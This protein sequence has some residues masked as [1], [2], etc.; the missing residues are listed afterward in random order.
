MADVN[1][2]IQISLDTSQAQAQLRQL[3]SQISSFN[4][5]FTAI[6]SQGAQQAQAMNRALMDGVNATKMFNARIIPVTSTVERFSNSLEKGKLS[7]GEYSRYATSQLPGMRKVFSQEFQMME[8]VATER[9][10]KMQA[11][12]VALGKSA[13]GAQEAMSITPTTLSRG[14]GT[15]MAV[16]VQR[17]QMFNKLIDDG[18]TKLLNW[19]KNTQWAG[20]QLMVGFTLPLAAL[21]TVAAQT[22]MELDKASVSF[23]RVYGDLSTTT[24][25]MEKNK[26]ALMDL[27][28]EY[29][30]Y[31]TSVADTVNLGARVAATGLEGNDMLA[32]TEQ[33]LRFATLGQM[34]YNTALDATISLQSAFKIESQDLAGTIDFLNAVENQTVLTIQ[35]IAA[36]IPRVAPVIKGLGG[37]VKDLAV[38]LTAMREGGVSAEQGSNALKSGLASLIN[39]TARATES[40]SKLGINMDAIINQNKGDLLGTVKAFGEALSVVGE[41]EQ[42]QALEQ[43]FGKFQYARMGALFENIA[44]SSSQATRAMDIM[45]MSMEELASLS[46]K[47]L[48]K[49]EEST[50]VK[51]EKAL[52]NLRLAIAPLGEAFL[53]GIMPIMEFLSNL[54]NAFNN[55]PD[56]IKNAMAVIVG[57]VGGLGPVF[58]MTLGLI[59]NGFANL[60]KGVQVLRK[61]LA[62]IR[63][64]A[65]N[66][67]VLSNAEIEA[68]GATE[69]LDGSVQGLTGSLLI[70][71]R[72]VAALNREYERYAAVAGL[73]GAAARTRG[74][75]GGPPPVKM[76]KGGVVPGTGSGDKIPALLEPGESVVTKKASQR[77]G[78]VIAAMNAGTL[79]GY[80]DGVVRVGSPEFFS[81][82]GMSEK[83][84]Q[85][86]SVQNFSTR[87]LQQA[88][89]VTADE[90]SN[91]A[92]RFQELGNSAKSLKTA[93]I[94]VVGKERTPSMRA[95]NR[96]SGGGGTR[97][98]RQSETFSQ[99][100]M[101]SNEEAFIRERL[102]DSVREEMFKIDASH[103]EKEV[104]DGIKQWRPENL[105][106]DFAGVNQTL[107]NR[108]KSYNAAIEK[109]TISV[110]QTASMMR[111]QTPDLLESLS[112]EE[113]EFEL[114]RLRQGFHPVTQ[115][116]TRVATSF[117]ELDAALSRAALGV[118]DRTAIGTVAA[119][120]RNAEFLA[121][122]GQYR[123]G[124][125]REEFFGEGGRS[126]TR[127]QEL[128]QRGTRDAEA[129][130]RGADAVLGPDD[131]PYLLTTPL[132]NSPHP[133][134][135]PDGRQDAQAYIT[136]Q[137][138]ELGRL[139]QAGGMSAKENY[140][141]SQ[142]EA[143]GVAYRESQMASIGMTSTQITRQER[144]LLETKIRS[145]QIKLKEAQRA[146]F[147]A[148]ES[149]RIANQ[150]N[151]VS[152]AENVSRMAAL[153]SRAAGATSSVMGRSGMIGMALGMGSMVPMMQ[154]NMGLGMGMMGAG[155]GLEMLGQAQKARA[156]SGAAGG[157]GTMA[158]LL[159][160]LGML[161]PPI[162]AAT[163]AV[164][165]LAIGAK[166]YRE[167]QDE[168]ARAA[169]EFGSNVGLAANS[170]NIMAKI[171]NTLTPAQRRA[172][173]NVGMTE[174]EQEMAGQFAS[175]FDSE[176]GSK[177]V[178]DLENATSAER[179]QKLSDYLRSAIAAGIMDEQVAVAFAKNMAVQLGDAVLGIQLQR[180]IAGQGTG[181]AAL[182]S[183][184]QERRSATA[185]LGAYEDLEG[186]GYVSGE[187]AGVIVGSALQNIQ[188]FANVIALAEEEY[189]SGTLSYADYND[190]VIQARAEMNTYTK[191]LL[192]TASKTSDVG[193]TMQA[194]NQELLAMGMTEEQMSS[195]ADAAAQDTSF[196]ER[197]FEGYDGA[198]RQR[199]DRQREVAGAAAFA[200]GMSPEN[201]NTALDFLA[202]NPESVANEI[203][204]SLMD[205]GQESQA[206]AGAIA[207]QTAAAGNVAGIG[208]EDQ[209]LYVKVL[210]EF[211][212]T[213]GTV[214]DFS[215]FLETIPEEKRVEIL[216]EF[217][218]LTPE[219]K[220]ALMKD[221]ASLRDVVGP[222]MAADIATSEGFKQGDSQQIIGNLDRLSKVFGGDQEKIQRYVELFLEESP[223]GF[224]GMLPEV[225]NDLELLNQIP[226]DIRS[227][228]GIDLENP[229]D[230][231]K[232][233]PLA[234]GIIRLVPA[235]EALPD[236]QKEVATNLMLKSNGEV[237]DP[238][239]FAKDVASYQKALDKLSS[240]K[241]EVRKEAAIDLITTITGPNGETV[242]AEDAPN[243]L[244]TALD[245]TG[246]TEGEFLQLP[247]DQIS[248]ILSLAIEAQGL[249]ESATT[250]QAMGDAAM[251]LQ[252]SSSAARY[253]AAAAAA[254]T[255]AGKAKES[256]KNQAAAGIVTGGN[257]LP[258]SGGGGGG[259]DK[260]DPFKDMKK[261]ILDQIQSYADM[262]ETMKTLFG[263]KMN[264]FDLVNK[265]KGIDDKIRQLNL[266]PALAEQISSMD[267][268]DAKKVLNR[269][270]KG[271]KLNKQGQMVNRAALAGSV[272]Q[273]TSDAATQVADSQAQM[274]ALASLKTRGAASAEAISSIAGD[275]AAAKEYLALIKEADK[276]QKALADAGGR[277]GKKLRTAYNEAKG[278]V[279]EYIDKIVE[280][281]RKAA[282]VDAVVSMEAD[283][284]TNKAA[285]QALN[286]LSQLS[287]VN[288]DVQDWAEQN[289][290]QF[291]N[292]IA[293][294]DGNIKKAIAAIQQNLASIEALKSP[295][296]IMMEELDSAYQE[297]QD[298]NEDAK[299]QFELLFVAIEQ[300]YEGLIDASK[301]RVEGLQDAIKIVQTEIDSLQRL[302]DVD[303]R[304]IRALERQKELMSRQVEAIE[305]Q[306]E[307]DQRRADALNRQAEM[308]NRQIEILDRA[309]ELD[310]R[311]IDALGRQI[312]MMTRQQD[313][314]NDQIA[315]QE[316]LNE[317]DQRQID[318]ITRSDELRQRQAEALNRELELMSRRE[319]EIRT[320]YDERIKQLDEVEQVQERI[321][322][323]SKSQLDLAKALASGDI[324]SAAAAAQQMRENQ[325]LSAR[326]DVRTAM[327]Q[328]MEGQVGALR[329]SGGLTREQAEGQVTGIQ[330]QSYQAQ[331]AIR[332]IQDQI[333][334]RTQELIPL[335]DQLYL[336]DQNI[337]TVN[338]EIQVIQ[339][340]VY[341]REL[342][343]I[344][345]LEQ[346]R[347][348]GI[349]VRD[350]ED[351]IYNRNLETLPI[352]DAIYNKDLEIR[353]VQD[354]IFNRETEIMNIQVAR[355]QP[356]QD[357]LNKE[358]D[359]LTSLQKQVESEKENTRVNGITY[360][361]LNQQIQ[362]QSA[363]YGYQK[364]M[365]RQANRQG[366][367]V[368]SLANL[369]ATVTGNIAAANDQARN[370]YSNARA[371][372]DIRAAQFEVTND[373]VESA[374][375]AKAAA[376]N[377]DA[378]LQQEY[379]RIDSQ[380]GNSINSALS[381]GRAAMGQ[382]AGGSVEG[383]GGRD[384]VLRLLA[385][386]EFVVRRS[387]VRKYGLPAMEAL[388]NGAMPRYNVPSGA[389]T[390]NSGGTSASGSA[391]VYN[392]YSV[393][394]NVPNA[395]IN[396]DEVANKVLYKIKSIESNSVRGYRGF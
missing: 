300:K 383:S 214:D 55:L 240:D 354:G 160:A 78:P 85:T 344:P 367:S 203:F 303:Q 135:G 154:G 371:L 286:D 70:Q 209:E 130:Q 243:V 390:V 121:A 273:R 40:L 145:E 242:S 322:K 260:K 158:K 28:K 266:T 207:A 192:D 125:G 307:L 73:A 164:G 38:M 151:V 267:P 17:Q 69:A 228:I 218:G 230:V 276:A 156:A 119:T 253:Y 361:Q 13:R 291:A 6:N 39:P 198:T 380:R 343:R 165:A 80:N 313:A 231:E 369:W 94:D 375:N 208:K 161:T 298:A 149:A 173:Q 326:Q 349:E 312:E 2:N 137:R 65:A 232:Y 316:R 308:I 379:A 190:I 197:M 377:A 245:A 99:Q 311:R 132:R 63:G 136:A 201:I 202:N 143:R 293:G 215:I 175:F 16:A 128:S 341:A 56:P 277:G 67:N 335:R 108:M 139:R 90:L 42:Q 356:L 178:Q 74:G 297:M 109:G 106:P 271:G 9:V 281:Q 104:V 152:Q 102:G 272:A 44:D 10:K 274:Q 123:L 292:M 365:I 301:E 264:F 237:K 225:V 339:D 163:A 19:G 31:G 191:A 294:Y 329:T 350:I 332:D 229:E 376:A 68:K 385:P 129:Y 194:I 133:K 233:G 118:S 49:I 1:A 98:T 250:L 43:I 204:Q 388:N 217:D 364:A 177:F 131:D 166:I 372:R 323:Q 37:D 15:E 59:G 235:L 386:G 279:Q 373:P 353:G 57:V 256:M 265:N 120:G 352:K 167:R 93:M 363:I 179:F 88:V 320:G 269:I 82:L 224:I 170:L 186:P 185:N 227:I 378:W 296:Q 258:T 285:A 180:T 210:T 239:A 212:E 280:A 234:E 309:T 257:D 33:T 391:P 41:F 105:M 64:D 268:T 46:E 24:A 226:P 157:A 96:E 189:M 113:V 219:Q 107:E 310:Q 51:F 261:A 153:K 122:S 18:S 22:F 4:Q 327:T 100:R 193:S 7:L 223:D 331:L 251:A 304:R 162:L 374:A 81:S 126:E 275:P 79:P 345:Y 319:Q 315:A 150:T 127:Y 75:R 174:Q 27:G 112:A 183:V 47:E 333:Y 23:E 222:T 142:S 134:A 254:R 95:F 138:T 248:K 159:P 330:D 21:G 206:L 255:A 12:Y 325:V 287:N 340:L 89:D 144:R 83:S 172:Q 317:L 395:N 306:N 30:K 116:A 72:A 196:L 355:L 348:I 295:E 342:E 195:M 351:A 382:F 20:R 328:G 241:L 5:S 45:G 29:T 270:S 299:A 3:Q 181:A 346:I 236:E 50:T 247:K 358:N 249:E 36:A 110:Q 289:P 359:V 200:G 52:E 146:A 124:E 347:D 318:I 8:R 246:L 77:F 71:R 368:A 393:N 324:Y 221:V 216:T 111:A 213:G 360:K 184:A 366:Q 54:A 284:A 370:L 387:M 182:L 211:V 396:A 357:A 394:V 60:V 115:N 199:G 238:I 321:N 384:S 362:S 336:I 334:T 252:D 381:A 35:D 103:I 176:E 148:A 283:T 187:N 62:R 76:A 11:Q 147:L 244:K 97:F 61:T 337:K 290:Q 168:A 169:A 220:S 84:R 288:E 389:G 58:L 48:S 87:A 66:F 205:A 338:A 14:Y 53:K 305:R 155:M 91:I 262:G 278:A 188:E 114:D 34:D 263:K 314:I 26:T 32:A 302:Q 25:E 92:S 282:G 101:F 171:A 140:S 392:T 259:G 86:Q 141:R 117:A